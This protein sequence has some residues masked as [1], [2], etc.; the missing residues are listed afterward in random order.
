MPMVVQ[1]LIENFSQLKRFY[2]WCSLQN[3]N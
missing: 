3:W 1:V 2:Y